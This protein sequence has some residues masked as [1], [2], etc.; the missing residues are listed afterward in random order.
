MQPPSK[1]I[2]RPVEREQAGTVT[3]QPVGFVSERDPVA[4]SMQTDATGAVARHF[5]RDR[6]ATFDDNVNDVVV[7]KDKIELHRSFGE[8]TF[9]L[10]HD[11]HNKTTVPDEQTIA[12][13]DLGS[14]AA[15][16]ATDVLLVIFDLF[17]IGNAT[18][19]LFFIGNATV[20]LFF[21]GNA[22]VVLFFIGNA[23][24][25]LVGTIE[26]ALRC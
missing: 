7:G 11:L 1:K 15:T 8:F 5:D 9:A 19:V 20:V 16:G 3:R 25:V 12:A 4:P 21:I 23:T 24:V 18:V 14:K 22:T 13:R 10:D 17:F 2:Q 26:L 6:P